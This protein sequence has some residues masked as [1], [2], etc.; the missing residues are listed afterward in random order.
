MQL[1]KI[2]LWLHHHSHSY[3]S[4]ALN[5]SSLSENVSMKC[6]FHEV[7]LLNYLTR[8]ERCSQAIMKQG[9]FRAAKLCSGS[10][11]AVSFGSVIF[12]FSDTIM[13]SHIV[14]APSLLPKHTVQRFLSQGPADERALLDQWRGQGHRNTRMTRVGEGVSSI[15]VLAVDSG[16]PQP[17]DGTLPPGVLPFSYHCTPRVQTKAIQF[18]AIIVKDIELEMIIRNS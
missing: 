13:L 8:H 6:Y 14:L 15:R 1:D 11:K 17:H 16:G 10:N 18:Y 5:M 2:I 4:H 12:G 9:V 7:S 3:V